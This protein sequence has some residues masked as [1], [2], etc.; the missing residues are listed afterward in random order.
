MGA[1]HN[2]VLPFLCCVPVLCC[3]A[4]QPA[5]GTSYNNFLHPPAAF[6]Q[7]PAD[8]FSI[9]AGHAALERGAHRYGE[10]AH[11]SRQLEEHMRA[12]SSACPYDPS[13]PGQQRCSCECCS[14]S[15][16]SF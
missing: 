16:F 2:L 15:L 10:L 8:F 9:G 11:L 7:S 3:C 6:L 4:A 1:R 13:A 14:P 5:A 12:T